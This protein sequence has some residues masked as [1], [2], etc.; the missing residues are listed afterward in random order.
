MEKEILV[1]CVPVEML[2]RLKKLAKKLWDES[3]PVSVRLNV[4]LDEF[5]QETRVLDNLAQE[6]EADYSMR[7]EFAKKEYEEKIARMGRETH[8]LKTRLAGLKKEGEADR[9]KMAKLNSVLRSK[10]AEIDA[11]KISVSEDEGRLNSKFIIKMQELYDKVNKKEL[12]IL[13][14]WEEKNR[15][16]ETKLQTAGSEAAERL[17]QLKLRAKALEEDFKMR[18]AKLSKTF[19]TARLELDAKEKAISAREEKLGSS[20]IKAQLSDLEKKCD[21]YREKIA[22]LTSALRRK[23][24]EIDALKVSAL[25]SEGQS[26]SKF[27]AKMQE[28]YDKVN[29]KDLEMHARWEEKNRELE[30]KS[31][32]A[33][34]EYAA[35]LKQ[36]KLRGKLL[37]EDFNMRKAELIQTSERMQIELDAGKKEISAREQK[38][39]SSRKKPGSEK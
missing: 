25:E 3:N 6:Y 31:Q 23:D 18:K 32:A 39:N 7:H 5:E 15:D 8:E 14:R 33:E 38:L 22:E 28:L 34:N 20:E 10:E 37:E 2:E 21:E 19:G 1:T 26:N 35:R 17:K 30:T 9:A 13:A 4:I 27:A 12:E 11:I 16:L 29:K 36:L 24:E